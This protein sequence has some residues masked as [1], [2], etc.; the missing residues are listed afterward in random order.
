[1]KA[2]VP[3]IDPDISLDFQLYAFYGLAMF[4]C[5]VLEQ[6]LTNLAV[7]MR[8]GQPEL[9]TQELAFGLFGTYDRKMFGQL[10]AAV[11]GAVGLGG[12]LQADLEEARKLR[13]HLAH[14]FWVRQPGDVVTDDDRRRLI[15]DLRVNIES[16]KEVDQRLDPLWQ[17]VWARYGLTQA[18]LDQEIETARAEGLRRQGR[19]D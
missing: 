10:L 5:Q 18:V 2:L 14:S 7:G 3:P 12:D 17:A 8:L 19:S 13:N 16:L 15:R 4:C 1:M 6:G 9:V 11:E